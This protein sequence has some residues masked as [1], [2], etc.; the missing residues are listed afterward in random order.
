MC[1]ESRP[2]IVGVCIDVSL[3]NAPKQSGNIT[4]IDA[5]RCIHSFPESERSPRLAQR[6]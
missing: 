6:C 4:G 5:R 3:L 2:P 1:Y